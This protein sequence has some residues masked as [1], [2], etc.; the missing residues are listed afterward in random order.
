MANIMNIRILAAPFLVAAVMVV[1][2]CATTDELYAEYDCNECNKSP[3]L[4]N[5][6]VITMAAA[7]AP[8]PPIF[9]WEPAIYFHWDRS[10]LVQREMHR[11]DFDL[12][13]LS[14]FPDATLV[15]RGFA[16]ATGS[17]EYNRALA[18]RRVTSVVTYL[19]ENGFPIERVRRAPLGESLP[20]SEDVSLDNLA[21]NRRVELMLVDE[22]GRPYNW[23]VQGIAV[24]QGTGKRG[25]EGRNAF[26]FLKMVEGRGGKA[27]PADSAA[28]G[29]ERKFRGLSEVAKPIRPTIDDPQE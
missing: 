18:S 5:V 19:V 25:L 12:K 15:V 16:D 7:S 8:P 4:N 23:A 14:M 1:Q 29:D 2:G 17:R 20:L 9:V 6:S 11:L 13:I 27:P 10:A 24:A 3:L 22:T 28:S 21:S 26:D